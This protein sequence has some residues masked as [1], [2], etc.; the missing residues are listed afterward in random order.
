M[1]SPRFP[2]YSDHPTDLV[3]KN[4]YS[5]LPE[6]AFRSPET[7]LRVARRFADSGCDAHVVAVATSEEENLLTATSRT[8]PGADCPARPVHHTC[9]SAQSARDV[10]A[11]IAAAADSRVVDCVSALNRRGEQVFDGERS[12]AG[13]LSGA[14]LALN[15][16]ESEPRSALE[17][18]QWL[19][20]LRHMT[21]YAKT[22][23]SV[24]ES[25]AVSDVTVA[26]AGR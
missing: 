24:P 9:R 17:A 19:S 18:V 13:I 14:S 23:E 15:V 12:P 2:L 16:A 1:T 4:R 11:L 26:P 21:Q 6:G 20:E 10:S 25:P 7:T 8:T 3:V 5:L 22:M